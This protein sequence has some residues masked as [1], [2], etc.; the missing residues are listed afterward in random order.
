MFEAFSLEYDIGKH[1]VVCV[2]ASVEKDDDDDVKNFDKIVKVTLS[3]KRIIQMT[4]QRLRLR[5]FAD[6]IM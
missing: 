6:G 4:R 3:M 5:R 1:L 2:C